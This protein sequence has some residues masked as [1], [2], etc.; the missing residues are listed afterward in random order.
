MCTVR[1]I[2]LKDIAKIIAK[3]YKKEIIFKDN[4]K[5][6]YLFADITKLKKIYKFNFS[7]VIKS[8]IF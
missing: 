6:T 1:V 2:Y 3:K 7:N 8:E 4:T 5:K